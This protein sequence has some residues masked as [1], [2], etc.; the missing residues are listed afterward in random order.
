MSDTNGGHEDTDK[1]HNIILEKLNYIVNRLDDISV[2]STTT[3][4]KLNTHLEEHAADNA[5]RPDKIANWIAIIA[6]ITSVAIAAIS[7]AKA[8]QTKTPM[9][10]MQTHGKGLQN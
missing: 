7:Y 9:E 3:T 10:E 2:E 5:K 8:G 1:I 4:T 6:V